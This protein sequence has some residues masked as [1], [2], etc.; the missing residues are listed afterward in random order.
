MSAVDERMLALPTVGWA[1]RDGNAAFET[2]R[3]SVRDA[4][5]ASVADFVATR[6]AVDLRGPGAD[7]A[8]E[9]VQGFVGGGK[10]V[11]STFA[12]LGWLC[13]ADAGAAA[14][15]AAASLE[16]LHAF[17]LLQDDVMDDSPV[18]RGRASAHVQFACW[19]RDR[20][21]SGSSSRFGESAAMLLGDL[22][23]VWAEQMLRGSG[24]A[25][26]ALD[27]A[28][29]RYDTMRTELAV[30]QLG[31]IVVDAA[32]L[33][34][35][36]EV[37][38]VARRKSGNYTV[39][40]PLEIGAVLAGCDDDVLTLLSGYGEA[41]GEAFQMRDDL[42]GIY[43]SP[44]VTGKPAG[45]DLSERKATTVVVAA[46]QLADNGLR[47]RLSELMG[48]AELDQSAVD[49]WRTLIA[50]TG[51]VELIEQ[52]IAERV[53]AAL[54]LLSSDRIDHGVRDALAEMALACSQRAA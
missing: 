15:R 37:L 6:C 11:R 24:L 26:D 16:L 49:Q 21:L 9:V 43:G 17:A 13:G 46:Y 53:A 29:P 5:L 25:R 22:C 40:W 3:A 42:L 48:S 18:R 14:L 27:R 7:I 41:V 54:E 28:W 47:R 12:L 50:A 34:S 36:T 51:A 23:L 4:V 45:A 1:Y 8:A 31:D 52:M 20:G 2:W 38:D 19:H 44:R 32:S 39:R 33:P 30:G 10:C 35:L